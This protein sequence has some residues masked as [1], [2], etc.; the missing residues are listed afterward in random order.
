MV[1]AVSKRETRGEDML[2]D[3]ITALN[4]RLPSAPYDMRYSFLQTAPWL[5]LLSAALGLLIG[6]RGMLLLR[7]IPLMVGGYLPSP[8]VFVAI[9][10]PLLA[11]GS[12][13]GLRDRQRW[14]WALFTTSVLIDL[15]FS[16][17]SF[18]I[19]SLLFGVLF[20][21]LLLQTYGEYGRRW[22]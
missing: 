6:G 22:R 17:W 7:V 8:L 13:V 1:R 2:D 3:F 19:F 5:A 18:D 12:F 20:L 10:S 14:G 11:L 9:A 16:L 15:G 4:Q 21:Y